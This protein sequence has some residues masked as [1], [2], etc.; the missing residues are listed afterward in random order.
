MAQLE[1]D[2]RDKDFKR[3]WVNSSV[4]LFYLQ[5]FCILAFVLGGCYSLYAH[6]YKG[7]PKVEVPGNTQYTPQYK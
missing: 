1:K 2:P 4:F 7:K 6:R 3:S 5:V